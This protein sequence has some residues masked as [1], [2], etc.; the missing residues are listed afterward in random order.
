M[1]QEHARGGVT[2]THTYTHNRSQTLK[3]AARGGRDPARRT[4]ATGKKYYQ[5]QKAE[6]C[7]VSPPNWSAQSVTIR[8]PFRSC[9]YSVLRKWPLVAPLSP[10]FLIG[11]H[12]GDFGEEKGFFCLCN[13]FPLKETQPKR[14]TNG[15]ITC[16]LTSVRVQTSS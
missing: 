12:F 7:R 2:F 4:R 9:F 16:K 6:S 1:R 10:L 5:S 11:G 3:P 13:I 8:V 15:F 14:S